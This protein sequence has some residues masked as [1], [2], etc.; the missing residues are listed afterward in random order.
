MLEFKNIY[1]CRCRIHES[2]ENVN[3]Q[4]PLRD[5]EDPIDTYTTTTTS[6]V[7]IENRPY[8]IWGRRKSAYHRYNTI[9]A[10]SQERAPP[11]GFS[12]NNGAVGLQELEF[13]WCEE[14][15]GC[16]TTTTGLIYAYVCTYLGSIERDTIRIYNLTKIFLFK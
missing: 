3:V 1:I 16:G 9:K 10:A 12:V 13:G 11:C 2:T 15:S 7:S 14:F 4:I 6:P 5:N 8:W